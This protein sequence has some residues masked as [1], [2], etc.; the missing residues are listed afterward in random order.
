MRIDT[1]TFDALLL[2]NCIGRSPAFSAAIERIRQF[3]HSKAPILISGETGTG[4]EYV[5]HA[6]HYLS[7]RCDAAFVP[8]N[9]GALPDSLIE[10]ELFGH[11]RGA[12]TDASH[13]RSGLISEAEG[14]TLFLDEVE[15]LSPRGQSSLLRFLQDSSFRCVGEEKPRHANVRVVAASNSNLHRI[16]ERGHFRADLLFRLDAL[17][18]HLPPLRERE[19]D[20][21]LLVTH[22]LEKVARSEGGERKTISPTALSMLCSY[23]WPGNVRELEHVL[24]RAHLLC[25]SLIIGAQDLAQSAPSLLRDNCRCPQIKFTGLREEKLRAV[26]EVERNFVERALARTNGNISEAARLS[27]T[28]RAAFSKLAKK[29]RNRHEDTAAIVSL[30]A[31]PVCSDVDR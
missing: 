28:E 25:A 20:I 2:G 21:P 13:A 24:L 31:S 27:K 10:S 23:A 14:G 30:V 29:Y 11:A 16:V 19:G 6:A 9:C 18:I 7:N 3:A 15:A 12:F 22:L 26:Q 1:R 17:S 8:V 4:K 5:A